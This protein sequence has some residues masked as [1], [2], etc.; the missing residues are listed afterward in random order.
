MG[1]MVGRSRAACL[2]LA[3]PF[4]VPATPLRLASKITHSMP[5]AGARRRQ[6]LA[7]L[8]PSRRK[9]TPGEGVSA[10]AEGRAGAALEAC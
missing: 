3:I 7:L 2:A 6:A 1:T 9:K 5:A 10:G 4:G 8:T